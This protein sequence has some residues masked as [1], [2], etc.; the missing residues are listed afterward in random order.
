MVVEQLKLIS[1][2]MSGAVHGV[3]V[4][5]LRANIKLSY[6]LLHMLDK[7]YNEELCDPEVDGVTKL[8]K[9]LNDR[10]IRLKAVALKLKQHPDPRGETQ[11][12]NTDRS[13][14]NIATAGHF[15]KTDFQ[16][17]EEPVHS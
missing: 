14:R 4:E 1:L 12:R 13:L 11:D 6:I 16:K 9:I 3:F 5:K 17:I 10:S 7:W 8:I 15:G 2:K